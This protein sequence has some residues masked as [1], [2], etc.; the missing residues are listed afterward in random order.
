MIPVHILSKIK[1]IFS[2]GDPQEYSQIDNAI[3]KFLPFA[4]RDRCGWHII[5]KGFEKYV[6][7][8]FPGIPKKVA[9]E[10]LKLIMNW[11]YSWMKIDCETY[12]QFKYS[13]HLLCK[14][15]FSTKITDKFGLPFA[16]NVTQFLRRHVFLWERWFLFC[17][18]RDIRYYKEYNNNLLE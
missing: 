4:K 16:N 7:S 1:I 8:S 11:C 6:Q 18:R 12:E 13:Y 14:Y 17:Y 3:Y 15:L 2:D 5:A 9:N 10:Q